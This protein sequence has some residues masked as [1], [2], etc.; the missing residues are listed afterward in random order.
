MLDCIKEYLM[1]LNNKQKYKNA[2]N[3]TFGSI[4][5]VHVF[6]NA[7]SFERKCGWDVY[8]MRCWSSYWK[9][10]A[11]KNSE[12]LNI[13]LAITK[14]V[15]K[16][17]CTFFISSPHRRKIFQISKSE[18]VCS[19]TVSYLILFRLL[20]FCVLFLLVFFLSLSRLSCERCKSFAWS[21][22]H[23]HLCSFVNNYENC[24]RLFVVISVLTFWS[25]ARVCVAFNKCVL[26]GVA[27][28]FVCWCVLSACL[29]T[30]FS[31]DFV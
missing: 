20:F 21:S 16:K 23:F 2:N 27:C 5:K 22:I 8:F 4:C 11:K 10:T 25:F 13:I 30:P 19:C 31:F 1:S 7:H 26:F 17:N 14:F 24:V 29:G 18:F 3:N 28:V 15:I 9:L 12:K 6:A